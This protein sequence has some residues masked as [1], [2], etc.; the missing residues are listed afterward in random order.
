MNNQNLI[1]QLNTDHKLE[2][3]EWLQLI[4]SYT[5]EDREYA[6]SLAQKIS[7]EHFDHDIYFR[8]IVEFSNYCK[9]DCFYCG[10]RKG[11][12]ECTRYR[13]SKEEILSC[14]ENGYSAG[15]RTF[16]LQGGEDPFY[17]DDV[18]C[19]II[20]SIHTPYPA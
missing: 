19:A 17:T 13:L 8:G 12:R 4:S 9:N 7:I 15:F 18:M 10:I 16:V 14:C 1:N 6:R 3:P 5:E 2:Y 11:N 20:S